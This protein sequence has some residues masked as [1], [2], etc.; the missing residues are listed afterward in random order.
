MSSVM[1]PLIGKEC[2]L[3]LGHEQQDKA[4]RAAGDDRAAISL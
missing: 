1:Y 3:T 4:V 2:F